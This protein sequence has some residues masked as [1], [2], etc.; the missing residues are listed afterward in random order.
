MQS[1]SEWQD[2]FDTTFPS[3]ASMSPDGGQGVVLTTPRIRVRTKGPVGVVVEFV[4]FD[5]DRTMVTEVIRLDKLSEGQYRL[6][7]TTYGWTLSTNVPSPMSEAGEE[8]AAQRLGF[9]S[10]NLFDEEPA[11]E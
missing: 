6:E 2:L 4:P 3:G 9:Y 5:S 1:L 10:T 8:I 11:A 7:T